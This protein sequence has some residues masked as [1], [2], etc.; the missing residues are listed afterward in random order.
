MPA[1]LGKNT[2]NL[3]HK[4][5]HGNN[6][7]EEFEVAAGAIIY[8]GQPVILAAGG[9]VTPAG[10]ATARDLIIGYSIHGKRVAGE[11][12][13]VNTKFRAVII[14]ASAAA[15]VAGPVK[16]SAYSAASAGGLVVDTNTTAGV[17]GLS[18]YATATAADVQ[19][20]ALDDA[21]A[22]NE[23]IRVGIF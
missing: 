19:A 1:S 6:I 9:K 2:Q 7:H 18:V 13:T 14:A 3:F 8:P 22:A 20:F 12:V 15:I 4:D 21:S 23:Q 17:P 16:Y 10:A 5:F 11:F